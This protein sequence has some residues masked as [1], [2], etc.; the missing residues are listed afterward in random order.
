MTGRVLLGG[1]V[2]CAFPLV[3]TGCFGDETPKKVRDDASRVTKIQDLEDKIRTQGEMLSM[4]DAQLAEQAQELR[5]LRKSPTPAPLSELVHVE[6]IEIDRLSGGYDENRDGKP[7]GIRV[8]MRPIDQFGG[9]LRAAGDIHVKLL[10]LTA[11]ENGQLVGE[12]RWSNAELKDLWYGALMSSE[13]Y[14]L[15]VPWRNSASPPLGKTITV[16]VTF[17]DLL[18]Q[19]TFDAQRAVDVLPLTP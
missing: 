11:P 1:V 6:K 7:D 16:L 5:Q 4:K 19:R 9:R 3:F 17:K 14:T 15:S 18:T 13:H 10:D 2:V 12:A 8:Y